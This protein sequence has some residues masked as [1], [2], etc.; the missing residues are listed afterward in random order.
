MTL[1]GHRPSES[2]PKQKVVR[3][4]QVGVPSLRK[5]HLNH[6]VEKV[7]KSTTE[8]NVSSSKK[9]KRSPMSFGKICYLY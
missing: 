7:F 4:Q 9:R 2:I 8:E 1:W 6:S 5:L 3:D